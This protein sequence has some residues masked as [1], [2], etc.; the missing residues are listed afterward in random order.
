[1]SASLLVVVGLVLGQ[2]DAGYVRTR[3]PDSQHCF[4]WA[5]AAGS[6]TTVT[7]VQGVAGDSALGP[8]F[9]DAVSRSAATWQARMQACGSLN[10]VEGPHSSSRV[11]GYDDHGSNENLVLVRTRDC[12]TVV[13][14]NDPCEA[15]ATCGNA[16]DCWDH[17]SDVLALTTVTAG[18]GD[19][20]VVDADTE[21][22]AVNKVPTL[23]DSPPCPIGAPSISCVANDVQSFDT[24]EFGHFLGL[25]HAPDPNSTMYYLV[26]YADTSRRTL[27]PGSLQF[28]CDVYP[29]DRASNDCSLATS[30]GN[31]AAGCST[32]G[33]PGGLAASL[34][35]LALISLALRRS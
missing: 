17:G 9:F 12:G 4:H 25:A 32:T 30:S 7:F 5:A 29:A 26:P 34:L 18:A 11:I 22:N 2:A 27:D 31:T 35:A 23:V 19:G 24:H 3:T 8:G 10:L 13:P 16:Y 6:R 1:M 33:A 15:T 21:I 28:V 14:V 20:V